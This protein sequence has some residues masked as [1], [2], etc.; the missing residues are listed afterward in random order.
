MAPTP[1]KDAPRA[2]PMVAPVD[3][4]PTGM[5]EAVLELVLVV[6][7]AVVVALVVVVAAVVVV[8]EA[9]VVVVVVAVVQGFPLAAA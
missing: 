2:M 3:R 6:V 4:S 9:A 1:P 8:V 7:L 5:A